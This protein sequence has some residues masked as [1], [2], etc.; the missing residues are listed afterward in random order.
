MLIDLAPAKFMLVAVSGG[1]EPNPLVF[2]VDL[3]IWSAL[4]FL[5]LLFVL[6][7]YAWKPILEGLDNREKAIADSIDS[8]AQAK[9]KAQAQLSQYEQKLAGASAEAAAIIAEAKKDALAAKD[10]IMADAAEEAKRTRDRALADIQAAKDAVVRELAESSV[11]SAVSLAGS[12]VGRSLN[13]NDHQDLIQKS[14]K[15]FG[16][17]A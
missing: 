12:I 7:K 6:G 14:I 11:D 8:A 16:A 10:R 17:G 13:K 1:E 15:Q 4:V 3:A 9:E 5:G 2:D